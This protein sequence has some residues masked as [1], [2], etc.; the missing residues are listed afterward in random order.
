MWITRKDRQSL[1]RRRRRLTR[2][3]Q[4]T[5]VP[6]S[7]RGFAPLMRCL[8]RT[9]MHL[10]PPAIQASL[11]VALARQVP[12]RLAPCVTRQ[13]VSF[14]SEGGSESSVGQSVTRSRL[15]R[16]SVREQFAVLSCRG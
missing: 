3:R 2:Y 13:K 12:Q 5:V 4:I 15:L 10:L 7:Q 11:S 8:A 9:W 1:E 16:P 6:L 14:P